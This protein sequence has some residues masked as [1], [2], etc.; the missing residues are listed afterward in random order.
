MSATQLSLAQVAEKLEVAIS[1]PLPE[2]AKPESP[3]PSDYAHTR[4]RD[5]ME[6]VQ[7][8]ARKVIDQMREVQRRWKE[9]LQR[10]DEQ[11]EAFAR[12]VG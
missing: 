12:M 7:L 8:D 10:L 11:I 9:Q 6:I 5:T 2:P 3:K 1:D 4:H